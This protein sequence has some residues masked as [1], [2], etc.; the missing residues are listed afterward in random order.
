MSFKVIGIGEVLWDLMPAG[1]QLGGAPANFAYHARSLG[2]DAFVVTRVGE[3]SLG[4]EIL[5]RFNEMKIA[6]GVVQIDASK[7]TGTVTVVL[8]EGGVPQFAIREE[9]AWDWLA[10]T[11]AARKIV[12]EADAICFG[13][14]AQRNSCARA[15]IQ[16][17]VAAGPVQA[18]RIFDI[19]LRQQYYSREII[20]QSLRLANVLKLNDAELTV[21]AGMFELGPDP[22]QQI[23][24]LARVF[25]LR[26][27]ALTRGSQGSLLYQAGRWS[28]E[29]SQPVQ[30]VDTVGAGDA[31]TAALTMGLLNKVDLDEVHAVAAQVARYVCSHTGA[32][33]AFPESLRRAIR[34]SLPQA[35]SRPLPLSRPSNQVV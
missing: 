4:R 8:Q 3:D 6:D 5:R 29:L 35:F 13:T 21:L 18:L 15:S 14:L 22:K 1:K 26:L 25:E 24:E 11:D 23:Q 2:A 16:Q 12:S 30:V 7:P 28:E 9:V 34:T 20:E 19:N 31:F 32:T 17:L 27:V 33:P 10:P